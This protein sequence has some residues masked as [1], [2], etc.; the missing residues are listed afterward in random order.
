MARKQFDYFK[1]FV[2][3]VEYAEKAAKTLHDSLLRFNPDN[4]NRQ[5]DTMH[6][7]EHAADAEKHAMIKQ[8]A[9]EFVTPIER[10]DILLLAS[11]IDEVTDKV[12]DVLIRMYM[13]NVKELRSDALA[14]SNV[15]KNSCEN[16]SEAVKEFANFRK[17]TALHQYVV[18]VNTMEEEGD[19]LYIKAMRTLYTT[20]TDPVQI[21]I[22]SEIFDCFEDCCDACE[23]VVNVMESIVMKNS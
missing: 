1:S 8:L 12:E 9:V 19:E 11:E 15:I 16:L 17:S 7:I 22:W 3:M 18:D 20:E 13:Y 5:R 2:T 4:L 10:E 23:H 21:L 14:F 6:A